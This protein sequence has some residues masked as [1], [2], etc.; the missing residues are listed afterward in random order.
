[1]STGTVIVLVVTAAFFTALILIAFLEYYRLRRARKMW[2]AYL[3][4]IEAQESW[5]GDRRKSNPSATS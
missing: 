1:M 2:V 4:E 5:A 3:H